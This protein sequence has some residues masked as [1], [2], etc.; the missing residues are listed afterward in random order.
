MTNTEDLWSIAHVEDYLYDIF[1]NTG[2]TAA[3]VIMVGRGVTT[4]GDQE[5]REWSHRYDEIPDGD[6]KRVSLTVANVGR[7]QRA[8]IDISWLAPGQE[9]RQKAT[10]TVPIP[11]RTRSDLK[12]PVPKFDRP[13]RNDT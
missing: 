10:V 8:V 5:Q 13:P 4:P 12:P 7:G 11:G 6:P 2:D 9:K 1:N 3:K